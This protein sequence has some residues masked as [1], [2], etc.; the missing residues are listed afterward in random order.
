MTPK[1]RK[2]DLVVQEL[3]GELLVYDLNSDKANCLSKSSALI[4]QACNGKRTIREIAE[5]VEESLGGPVSDD[6]VLF[7]IEQLNK[8]DLLEVQDEY[9]NA[10]EGMSR[11]DVIKRVG[12]ASAIALPIVSSLTAPMAVHAISCPPAGTGMADIP[13]GSGCPCVQPQ[14]C[15]GGACM[16]GTMTC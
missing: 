10:F 8:A 4:W 16:S 12:L 3:A 1:A 15:S 6:F 2:K 5:D 7:A 13:A 11:R 14:D 9:S